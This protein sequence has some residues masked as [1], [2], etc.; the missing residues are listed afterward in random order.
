MIYLQ[1]S[2]FCGTENQITLADPEASLPMLRKQAYIPLD[3]HKYARFLELTERLSH[4][5]SLWNM[6][7]NKNPCAAK[8]VYSAM[9]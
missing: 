2:E 1:E 3:E 6:A 4:Q 5:V 7:C 9:H 8:L